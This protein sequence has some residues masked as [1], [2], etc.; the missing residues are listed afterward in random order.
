MDHLSYKEVANS[1][2]SIVYHF[3]IG[4]P[5]METNYSYLI[6]S[7]LQAKNPVC[8][9]IFPWEAM[10]LVDASS[11]LIAAAARKQMTDKK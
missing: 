5:V 8:F 1:V 4:H 6:F 7:P 11:T 9:H 2:K 3:F 10:V